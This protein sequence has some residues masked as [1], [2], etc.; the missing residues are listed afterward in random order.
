MCLSDTLDFVAIH[1]SIHVL[2]LKGAG[3]LLLFFLQIVGDQVENA[4]DTRAF[5]T[6]TFCIVRMSYM[7]KYDF[8]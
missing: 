8:V 7:A 1:C 2:Q 4:L 3:F 6:I 5:N